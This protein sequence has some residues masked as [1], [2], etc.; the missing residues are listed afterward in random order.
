MRMATIA[1]LGTGAIGTTLA[2]KWKAAGHDVVLGSRDPGSASSRERAVA[3]GL[4][5][6]THADAVRAARAVLI[7][8]PGLAVAEVASS[9]GAGLEGKL[10]IDASNNLGAPEVNSLGA[11]RASAPAAVLARAFNS[12]G[13]ENFAHPV[14]AGVP[15]DLFWCGPDGD[16]GALVE[17]LVSDVG[18]RP[19]RVG[20]LDQAPLVDMLASL[21]FALA[22]GQGRGRHL[23]F[24]MLTEG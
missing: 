14:F 20:A 4:S 8:L 13:W 16:D 22:L 9:L 10:V 23:A 24:K 1:V 6:A 19:V 21:W 17:R 3:V 5:V 15:A 12:L 7:A 11:L 18:L 2:A